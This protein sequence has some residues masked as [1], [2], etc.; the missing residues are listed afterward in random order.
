MVP[1]CTVI[2]EVKACAW[3]QIGVHG[4]LGVLTANTAS[5]SL[6]AI[7]LPKNGKEA[8]PGFLGVTPTIGAIK[9]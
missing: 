6:Q 3:S 7:S 2:C 5:T 8:E 9:Y 1:G 4:L